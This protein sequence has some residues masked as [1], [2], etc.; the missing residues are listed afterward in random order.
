MGYRKFLNSAEINKQESSTTGGSLTV[1]AT[2]FTPISQ[3]AISNFIHTGNIIEINFIPDGSG[4]VSY[5]YHST[6]MGFSMQI[7]CDGTIISTVQ[8]VSFGAALAN[9]QHAIYKAAGTYSFTVEAKVT[10][11]TARL[12][13]FKMQVRST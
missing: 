1:T 7:K 5:V 13:Y 6:L 9:F 3:L 8:E 11:N 12:D 10:S 2:S 4:N